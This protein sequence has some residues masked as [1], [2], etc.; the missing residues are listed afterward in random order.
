MSRTS[1]FCYLS[2]KASLPDT[3]HSFFQAKLTINQPNDVY[4]RE[5]D[6]VADSVMQPHAHA[7]N[8]KAFFKPSVSSIQRK[9]ADCETEKKPLQRKSNGDEMM[10]SSVTSEYLGSLSGGEPLPENKKKLL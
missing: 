1:S 7:T 5:A 6:R 2:N 3:N 4:E 10:V 9:C 8:G